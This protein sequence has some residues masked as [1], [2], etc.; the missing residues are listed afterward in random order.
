MFSEVRDQ[1]AKRTHGAPHGAPTGLT[2]LNE[3][4]DTNKRPLRRGRLL[5]MDLDAYLHDCDPSSPMNT[6]RGVDRRLGRLRLVEAGSVR[7]EDGGCD[8]R[9]QQHRCADEEAIAD[10]VHERPVDDAEHARGGVRW[11]GVRDSCRGIPMPSP[12]R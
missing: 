10:G 12:A 8:H 11:K 3:T 1:P 9:N 4:P 2:L 6:A 5:P 7:K